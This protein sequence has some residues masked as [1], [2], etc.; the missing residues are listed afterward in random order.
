MEQIYP[1]INQIVYQKDVFI[2]LFSSGVIWEQLRIGIDVS[3]R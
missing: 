1:V 2:N 3:Q